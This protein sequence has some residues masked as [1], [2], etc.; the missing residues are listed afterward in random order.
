LLLAACLLYPLTATPVR[1]QDRFP[2]STSRTLDGTAY[3]RTSVYMDD[4]RPLT[5]EWDRQAAQWLRSNVR[6]L[7]T[8]LEA[9]TPLYRWGSRIAVYTGFPTVIGWDW[10]QKQQR[11]VLPGNLIDRRIENVRRI[12]NTTDVAEAQALLQQLG[13][14]FIVVGELERYYYDPDGLAKFEAAGAPW[15]LAYQNENVKIYT[16]R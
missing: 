10:H 6:G 7:P 13:V 4:G 15:D 14:E 11:S 16:P 8:V 2:N 3:M 1:I 9:T 12:Y 5:L